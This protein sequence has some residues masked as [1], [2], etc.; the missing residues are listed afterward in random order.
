MVAL[1]AHRLKNWPDLGEDPLL[2][3]LKE[4]AHGS[5]MGDSQRPRQTATVQIIHQCDR[6]RYLHGEYHCGSL[7][8]IRER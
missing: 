4:Y 7:A 1:G 6:S 3:C 8:Q 5:E 2:L